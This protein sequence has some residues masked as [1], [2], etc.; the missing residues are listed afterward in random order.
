M[1]KS[2]DT[3]VSTQGLTKGEAQGDTRKDTLGHFDRHGRAKMVDVGSKAVT[4][5]YACAQAC[6]HM[7]VVALRRILSIEGQEKGK[8]DVLA[9]ARV[10]GIM[11]A[12]RTSDMIPLCHPLAL[13]WIGI[14]FDID[15]KAGR[16][17]VR[18]ECRTEDRTGV[19][20]EALSGVNGAALTIYDMAKA[21]DRAM[22]ITDIQ[23]IEKRGGRSG[24]YRAG[25][26][27]AGVSRAG[28]SRAGV[29]Q[30]GIS[31]A[32]VSRSS[33]DDDS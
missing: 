26:S 10:A 19:E 30:A 1:K 15:K 7:D 21:F 27:Q 29:S 3:R 20:M 5:R 12:K 2:G 8:G 23:L 22:R 28:V 14:D 9:V 6:V 32:G 16:I 4:Q 24:V 25:V 31:Q 33:G 13:S 17:T 18:C 11:A